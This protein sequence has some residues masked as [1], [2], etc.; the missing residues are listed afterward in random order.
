MSMCVSLIAPV[1][2]RW[3][4]PGGYN[5]GRPIAHLRVRLMTLSSRKIH[6]ALAALLALTAF[7]AVHAATPEIDAAERAIAAAESVAPRGEAAALLSQARRQLQQA[8]DAEDRRRKR[9]ALRL[10]ELAAANADLAHARARLDAGRDQVE[11]NS[12]RNVDLRRRLLLD[13]DSQ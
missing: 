12:A 8:R 9:D 7:Q 10:A 5:D 13:G 6:L 1:P 2:C 3:V 4:D 11:S